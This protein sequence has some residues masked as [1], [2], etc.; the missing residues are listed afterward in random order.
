MQVTIHQFI[1]KESFLKLQNYFNNQDFYIGISNNPVNDTE[2]KTEDFFISSQYGIFNDDQ[3]MIGTDVKE[4]YFQRDYLNYEVDQIFTRFKDYIEST[5]KRNYLDDAKESKKFILFEINRVQ[6]VINGKDYFNFLEAELYEKLL[7][8]FEQCSN[9][10][11]DT[12]F[13]DSVT[14]DIGKIK[15]HLKEIDFLIL[16][17]ALRKNGMI[18]Y[19]T[20]DSELARLIENNFYVYDREIRESKQLRNIKSRLS[21]YQ[22]NNKD[23]Q[24]AI[25]RLEE[26]F[27]Q[28]DFF[29]V[30]VEKKK[31]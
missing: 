28:K 8:Q 20:S 18:E 16:M 24:N 27:K 30:L 9:Y 12:K 15:I 10:I 17:L 13:L 11:N 22:G 19:G 4:A 14:F 31:K 21:E 6:E 2:I 7:R 25:T 1:N 5:I 29:D 3:I 23:I 26:A